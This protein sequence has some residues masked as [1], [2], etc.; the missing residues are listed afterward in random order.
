MWEIQSLKVVTALETPDFKDKN[1]LFSLEVA[2][3]SKRVE[4]IQFLIFYIFKL[5]S[6]WIKREC[7]FVFMTIL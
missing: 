2:M 1:Q 6:I 4:F 3:A 5:H 7:F